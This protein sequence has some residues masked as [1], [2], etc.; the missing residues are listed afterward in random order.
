[1][2]MTRR[3]NFRL[4]RFLSLS[5]VFGTLVANPAGAQ[6]I[7]WGPSVTSMGFGGHEGLGGNP[8]SVTSMGF[9][10]NGSP[11]GAGH[12]SFS[13]RGSSDSPSRHHRPYQTYGGYYA[14]PVF[15]DS[16]SMAPEAPREANEDE[17]RGGPTIFDRRGDGQYDVPATHRF[18]PPQDNLEANS[19][20][21]SPPMAEVKSQPQTVLVFKDGHQTNVDNYAIIGSTLYD[22]SAGKRR[23]IALA[24]LDLKATA[25]QND[26]RGV[27]F[28]L[29]AS[30]VAN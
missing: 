24:D 12:I 19:T 15:L 9:G 23:K 7:N 11:Y 26:D 14:Y 3:L 4:S 17:Y 1:M 25:Q 6:T 5:M 22:L 30:S 16:Y 10:H 28:E 29:P 13:D 21:I 2:A 27:D 18:Q 20:P 8:P